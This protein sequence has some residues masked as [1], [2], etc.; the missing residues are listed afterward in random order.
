M[1]P[2]GPRHRRRG[3]PF[4]VHRHAIFR[5]R[6]PGGHA[7]VVQVTGKP[8][9]EW[10]ICVSIRDVGRRDRAHRAAGFLLARAIG[11]RRAHN[12]RF[13]QC[14]VGIRA[15]HAEHDRAAHRADPARAGGTLAR[16]NRLRVFHLHLIA[17]AHAVGLNGFKF[18][19]KIVVVVDHRHHC[20]RSMLPV[21]GYNRGVLYAG[22]AGSQNTKRRPVSPWGQ[23]ASIWFVAF[24]TT[25]A[26]KLRL[27]DF[28]AWCRSGPYAHA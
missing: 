19:V 27:P 13:F 16:P 23:T 15:A 24:A 28:N 21:K 9:G 11:H 14:R 4:T 3:G 8:V 18:F 20:F 17:A 22:M 7:H 6:Q 2:A 1:H 5:A 26:A 12:A 10:R 25:G